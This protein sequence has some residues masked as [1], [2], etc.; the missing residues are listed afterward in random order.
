MTPEHHAHQNT[1]Q[2]L[3]QHSSP[4]ISGSHR[5]NNFRAISNNQRPSLQDQDQNDQDLIQRVSELNSAR[6]QFKTNQRPQ[7]QP[8]KHSQIHQS[9]SS[10]QKQQHCDKDFIQLCSLV[11]D[12]LNREGISLAAP[13]FTTKVRTHFTNIISKNDMIHIVV[14]YKLAS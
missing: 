9:Q 10:P 5:F 8:Q 11:K 4:A 7:I 12:K 3:S 14:N 1:R 2:N 13:P 6:L